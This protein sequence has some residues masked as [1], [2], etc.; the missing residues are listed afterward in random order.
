[1][2]N[3]ANLMRWCIAIG[4]V[5]WG[6]SPAWANRNAAAEIQGAAEEQYLQKVNVACDTKLTLRFDADSLKRH[7]RDIDINESS[8]FRECTEPLRYLYYSCQSDSGRAAVKAAQLR[9]VACKGVPGNTGALSV[10]N[11]VIT[12]DRAFQ[13]S[14]QYTRNAAA[15]EKALG[16]RVKLPQADPYYDQRWHEMSLQPNPVAAS[17][18]TYCLLNAQKLEFTD[19]VQGQFMYRKDNATLKCVREGQVLTDLT[20]NQGR[21]TGF[22]TER[23]L[24]GPRRTGWLDDRRHGEEQHW[25]KD[26]K[27]TH[28]TAW[29]QGR[30]LWAKEMHPSGT[31]ASYWRK[32]AETR[33]ELRQT[34]DGK[35]TKLTCGPDLRDDAEL[36]RM[37]GFGAESTV[38]VHDH[39]GKVKQIVTYKNGVIQKEAPGESTLSRQG[40]VAYQDGKKH[41][42]ER[43]LAAN[44]KLR[45]TMQWD[46]GVLLSSRTYADDGVKV[47]LETIWKGG[48][49]QKKTERFL[50]GNPKRVDTFDG[51]TG[52]QQTYWDTG[53]PSK[54]I[55]VVRCGQTGR[56]WC[57][58]GVARAWFENGTP[59]AEVTFRLGKRHG[60]SKCWWETGKPMCEEEYADGKI[61]K[62]KRW[63][64]DGNPTADE[65]FEADGSRKLKR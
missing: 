38:S 21:K 43:V 60:S 37:C 65:E 52:R 50:N 10:A 26:G 45:E 59:M 51:N 41:G 22:A 48:E 12:V 25:S 6:V 56:Q 18:T 33:G 35:V 24:D 23:T 40:E 30:A 7:N 57:E 8:G 39:Y 32:H 17:G 34:A 62:S 61:Q 63:D 5:A 31:L 36:R 53:K 2:S 13:D 42:E 4:L 27:L 64:K 54:D 3:R 29:D 20:L 28:V 49:L 1:M 46:R 58:D 9:Q 44:G 55:S 15:F 47:V 19:E 11:G 16:I 14:A